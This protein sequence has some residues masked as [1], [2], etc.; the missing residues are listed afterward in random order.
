M[1]EAQSDACLRG[2]NGRSS[3]SVPEMKINTDVVRF[4]C[5]A[6]IGACAKR[7]RSAFVRT[8]KEEGAHYGPEHAVHPAD[9]RVPPRRSSTD[10]STIHPARSALG[11]PITERITCF[12]S[13]RH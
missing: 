12:L 5:S 3:A 4:A 1:K 11:M 13:A 6:M 2:L 10:S 9:E 7:K 8:R